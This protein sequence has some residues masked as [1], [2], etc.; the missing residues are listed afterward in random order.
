MGDY[1]RRSVWA[2]LWQRRGWFPL[3]FVLIALSLCTPRPHA[4][5]VDTIQSLTDADRELI[6]AVLSDV[7]LL[8]NRAVSPGA[9][10]EL[11]EQTVDM[12]VAGKPPQ[13]CIDLRVA[14]NLPLSKT[15]Q[16]F[17]DL[18]AA[19]VKRNQRSWRV[20][21]LT[22]GL[23]ATG[24]R[25]LRV[26]APGFAADGR[27]ALLYV[28]RGDRC[29]DGSDGSGTGSIIMAEREADYWKLSGLGAISMDA[30]CELPPQPS[31]PSLIRQLP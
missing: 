3:T 16:N 25:L 11:A 5:Q 4:S 10:L 30:I 9:M 8:G 22:I 15:V 20:G 13:S 29:P 14:N 6:T 31:P 19:F 17:D 1:A 24:N 2:A 7:A 26:S 23:S 27:R 21:T 18:R 12:C 28:W